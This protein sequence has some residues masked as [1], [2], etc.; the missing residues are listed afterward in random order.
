VS[1]FVVLIEEGEVMGR[2]DLGW[3]HALMYNMRAR[4]CSRVIDLAMVQIA[5]P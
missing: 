5:L 4:K 2:F 1:M 3:L